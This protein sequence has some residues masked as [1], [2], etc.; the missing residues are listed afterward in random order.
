MRP[1]RADLHADLAD[2][3]A[4]LGGEIAISISRLPQIQVSAE[5]CFLRLAN[6]APSVRAQRVEV[7]LDLSLSLTLTLTLT[8]TLHPNPDQACAR[9]DEIGLRFSGRQIVTSLVEIVRSLLPPPRSG[10]IRSQPWAPRRA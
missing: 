2:L 7:S 6:T 8:P 3:R 4:D 5:G 10:G 1:Q 9:S